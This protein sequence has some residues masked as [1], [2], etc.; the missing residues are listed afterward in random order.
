MSDQ[1]EKADSLERNELSWLVLLMDLQVYTW[2]GKFCIPSGL[3][4]ADPHEC[5]HCLPWVWGIFMESSVKEE[6]TLSQTRKKWYCKKTYCR[7][8]E[9]ELR[10]GLLKESGS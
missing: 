9:W 3:S 5:Y 1:R 7:G 6:Y 2:D 4:A 10:V 8:R